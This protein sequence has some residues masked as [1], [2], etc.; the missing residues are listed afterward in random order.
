MLD[1][2]KNKKIFISA[3][4]WGL[5]HCTRTAAIIQQLKPYNEIIIFASTNQINFFSQLFPDIR[6]ENISSYNINFHPYNFVNNFSLIKLFQA[7]Q[8]ERQTLKQFS[9]HNFLPDVIISDQRYGFYHPSAYN[10]FITHQ[11]N[12][13]VPFYLQFSNFIHQQLIKNF[14][15]VWIPDYENTNSSLAGKLSHSQNKYLNQKIK[16]IHPQ[17]LMKKKSKEKIIDYLFIISGTMAEKNYYEKYFTEIVQQLLEKNTNL[18]IKIIGG[19]KCD[20]NIYLGWKNY[21]ESSDLIS[22]SKNIITRPGYSTLMDWHLIKDETQKLFLVEP[23]FQY[24]QKYL[25]RYWIGKNWA[26]SID[27]LFK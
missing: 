10:I 18:I 25:Y 5:G 24:E 20:N 27:N 1:N 11:I 17:S 13:Q 15:E 3:L 19:N 22:S 16:Y 14:D 8:Q 9:H 6:I 26:Y 21:D 12:L 23:K 4:D 7:I 2:I